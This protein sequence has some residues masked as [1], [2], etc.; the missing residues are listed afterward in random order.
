MTTIIWK[1][2]KTNS[3]DF[4]CFGTCFDNQLILASLEY[5]KIESQI[6]SPSFLPSFIN[7][8]IVFSVISPPL[9]EVL[10]S[11][12]YWRSMR[13]TL[14]S[15]NRPCIRSLYFLCSPVVRDVLLAPLA[16]SF[17][18]SSSNALLSLSSFM[19]FNARCFRYL[20]ISI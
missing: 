17:S 13:F 9:S 3:F 1:V 8:C 7:F 12:S 6:D 20:I 4:L 11:G 10:V 19:W 16:V 15:S 5:D 14:V 18:Y 2:N